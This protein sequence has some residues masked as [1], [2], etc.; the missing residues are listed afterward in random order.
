MACRATPPRSDRASAHDRAILVLLFVV[1]LA[2]RL[3]H[4][5][6]PYMNFAD[7]NTA[8]FSI[9][10]RNY[11]DHGWL[12]TRLGQLRNIGSA[13]PGSYVVFAHHPPTIALLTSVA[14]MVLGVSEPAARTLPLVFSAATTGILFLLARRVVGRTWGLLAALLFAFSPGAIYFGQMLDHE[15]F[16]VFCGLACLWAWCRHAETESRGWWRACLALMAATILLDWPGAYLAPAI[17]AASW[18]C[19]ATRPRWIRLAAH[20]GATASAALAIVV[21]HVLVIKGTLADLAAS[22]SVRVLS[23]PDLAFTWGEY[24]D[25][26]DLRHGTHKIHAPNQ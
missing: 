10:A 17:A 19:P 24:L 21:G 13:D 23:T 15:A 12:A 5:R 9:F 7:H 14:F 26:I 22:L 11:L 18:L 8:N 20:S 25:R 4:V 6:S 1:A 3:Y 2:P 16:V